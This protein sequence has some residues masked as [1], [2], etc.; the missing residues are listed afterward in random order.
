[1]YIYILAGILFVPV[2]TF[3]SSSSFFYLM[4]AFPVLGMEHNGTI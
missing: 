1:M 4:R 2:N 3:L